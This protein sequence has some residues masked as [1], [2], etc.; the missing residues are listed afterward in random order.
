MA[1]PAE[2]SRLVW[3]RPAGPRPHRAA[4]HA[5][6]GNPRGA[7]R[8]QM[9]NILWN[10]VMLWNIL[11]NIRCRLHYGTYCGTILP[12]NLPWSARAKTS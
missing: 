10:H 12:S 3:R 6:G 2:P 4:H 1:R 7:Q 9:K 5:R 8:V 11:W